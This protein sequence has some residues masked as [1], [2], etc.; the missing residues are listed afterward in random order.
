M[1]TWPRVLH[2]MY[3]EIASPGCAVGCEHYVCRQH[4]R[5]E[6]CNVCMQHNPDVGTPTTTAAYTF[7]E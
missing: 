6:R 4:R 2:C 5:K 1:L 3:L 7:L